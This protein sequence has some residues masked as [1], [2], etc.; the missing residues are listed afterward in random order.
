MIT[1]H[2]ED[3]VRNEVAALVAFPVNPSVR[4]VHLRVRTGR[5][6]ILA[7]VWKT[8]RDGRA[9]TTGVSGGG[10]CSAPPRDRWALKVTGPEVPPGNWRRQ[11]VTADDRGVRLRL[12]T[13]KAMA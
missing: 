1:V 6:G 8:A 9:G 13:S 4:S 2:W 5:T 7:S 11:Q 3:H 10:I 12:L